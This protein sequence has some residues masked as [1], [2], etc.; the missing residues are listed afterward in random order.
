[1]LSRNLTLDLI[2]R[3]AWTFGQA[4]VATFIALAPG[5]L[6]APNLGEARALIV[7]A[8]A[9]SVAAGLSAIKTYLVSRLL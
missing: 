7:A 4:F 9:A 8:L 2:K 6:A 5:L 1:M 3:A